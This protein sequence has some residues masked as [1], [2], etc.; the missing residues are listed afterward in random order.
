MNFTEFTG[1]IIDGV[2]MTKIFFRYVVAGILFV[3]LIFFNH[4]SFAEKIIYQAI[5]DSFKE[6]LDKQHLISSGADRILGVSCNVD[7]INNITLS[8]ISVYTGKDSKKGMLKVKI[9]SADGRYIGT[10]KY[11]ISGEAGKWLQ[12]DYPTKEIEWLKE[13]EYS[14]KDLGIV[15]QMEGSKDFMVA[16]WGDNPEDSMVQ[17][18]LNAEQSS[19]QFLYVD[20]NVVKSKNCN[21]LNVSTTQKY[22]TVC[23][24]SKELISK[25][26]PV[27]LMRSNGNQ[28]A[29]R[30]E[31]VIDL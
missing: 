10:A 8:N 25:D 9:T 17:I 13:R 11:T 3:V 5:N 1:H 20:D 7:D 6:Y 14:S 4:N 12:L 29:P 28:V 22:D 18:S 16:S 31:I 15:A 23:E 26:K 19:T 24:I 21:K 2:E 27:Y 30:I